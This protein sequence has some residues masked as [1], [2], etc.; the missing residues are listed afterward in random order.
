MGNICRSPSAEGFFIKALE[1]SDLK[2]MIHTDSAGTHGYHVGHLPDARAVA[3]AAEFGVD[4]SQLR[5]RKV[6]PDDFHRY[7]LIVAMDHDNL[8]NL[9]RMQPPGARA[10]LK[11]MLD[12]HPDEHLKEV[13]D[14]YYGG[15]DGFQY[16]C[17]LLETATNSLL[18]DVGSG[19]N[20]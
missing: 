19:L 17:E 9:K 1:Q 15:M 18:T 4:I 8:E 13:P 16:M 3:T 20:R 12:Y 5:A 7:D 14:P 10:E 11:M 2:S 6:T